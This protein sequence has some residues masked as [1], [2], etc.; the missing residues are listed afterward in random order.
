MNRIAMILGIAVIVLGVVAFSSMF[1]VRQTEQA[2]VLQ[3]GEPIRVVREPGLKFKIPFVQNVVYY[4]L[5][6]MDLDPASEEIIAG[7]SKRVV[8]DTYT[9]Y[10]IVDPLR[11]FQTVRNEAGVRIQLSRLVNAATRA[12]VGRFPL[13]ALLSEQRVRIMAEIQERVNREAKPLGIE[14]VDVRIRRAD[15][16]QANSEAI[17]ARMRSEREREAKE[18][19]AQGAEAG[20]RIRA[21]ADR[22]RAVI[23]A[24]ARRT[25]EQ[26]RGQGDGEAQAIYNKAYGGE[27][28]EFYEFYRR[29]QAFRETFSS[30]DSTLVLSPDSEFFRYF[31]EIDGFDGRGEGA[32]KGRR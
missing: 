18:F 17:Y 29:M 32:A 4:D 28:R 16:P 14:I 11:F 20:A 12:V 3:F 21:E 6:L 13:A 10:R 8:A 9:R 25:A 23:L 24:E 7:D 19:R 27:A 5:R 15:L 1:V 30:G 22:E 2:L 26:L 31:N